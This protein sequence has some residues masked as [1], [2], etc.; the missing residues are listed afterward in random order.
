MGRLAAEDWEHV[1][2]RDLLPLLGI[3][4]KGQP[5]GAQWPAGR[6]LLPDEA[7]EDLSAHV[8]R[9]G[10]EDIL[11]VPPAAWLVDRLRYR[12]LYMPLQVAGIGERAVGLWVR[13]LPVPG[14][15]A[16]VPASE[17]AA[18]ETLAAGPR[19]RLVVTGQAVTLAVRYGSDGDANAGA[20]TR[21]ARLRAAG[22]PSLVP[23]IPSARPGKGPQAFLLGPDDH[24]ICAQWRSYADCGTCTVAVTSRELIVV[25]SWRPPGRPWRRVRRTLYV[26]R[27]SIERAVP[28]SR[29]LYLDSAGA[30]IRIGL[31][32]RRIASASSAWLG[33]VLGEPDYRDA[34]GWPHRAALAE[35]PAPANRQDEREA[36][37][38]PGHRTR[39]APASTDPGSGRSPCQT[40]MAPA[41]SPARAPRVWLRVGQPVP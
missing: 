38:R 28:Q 7:Y 40:R 23:A 31:G 2:D 39:S 8:G 5:Q 29:S 22:Q 25:R 18:I 19:R 14:V 24:C 27:R 17:I 35:P 9:L 37:E 16:Q 11:V 6:A 34:D 3:A 12:C 26:P 41:P 20:W 1:V 21:R 33:Q 32:S 10:V 13:A 4:I 36:G 15:R 30:R